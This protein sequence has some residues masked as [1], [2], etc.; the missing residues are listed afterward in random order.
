MTSILLDANALLWLVSAPDR[1]AASAREVLEHQ[2][3]ELSV[4]AVSAWEVAI[5]TRI[6]RMIVAQAAR[7]GLTIATSD[8]Q[9]IHGALTP[10]LVTQ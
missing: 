9:L 7:R 1:V 8:S 2:A 10:V 4:S 6:G 3:N 5:K